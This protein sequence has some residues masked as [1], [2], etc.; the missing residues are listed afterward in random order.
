MAKATELVNLG[1]TVKENNNA[2][3]LSLWPNC[4]LNIH[5]VKLEDV[6]RYI[7]RQFPVK[8]GPQQGE[9]AVVALSLLTISSSI[10][11]LELKPGNQ[12]NLTCS[13]MTNDGPGVCNQG[14][15]LNWLDGTGREIQGDI[16]HQIPQS[17]RPCEALLTVTP[18]KDINSTFRCELR[19]ETGNVKTFADF[20]IRLPGSSQQNIL[21]VSL[22]G[23]AGAAVLCPLVVLVIRA[24]KNKSKNNRLPADD[25]IVESGDD[26]TYV[27]V[28]LTNKNKPLKD[29]GQDQDAVIY[30]QV[31]NNSEKR[32]PEEDPIDSNLYAQVNKRRKS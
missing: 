26:V 8:G 27:A 30:S 4:S 13:L 29:K 25:K 21:A 12:V 10:P 5:N 7:C 15:K 11:Q 24:R 14:F 16:G 17:Q 3:R 20:T 2:E 9:D 31:G 6:S 18:Q 19:D 32:Q 23:A 28:E 1:E 22:G